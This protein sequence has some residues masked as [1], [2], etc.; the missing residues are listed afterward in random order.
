MDFPLEPV[1]DPQRCHEFLIGIFHPKGLKC[2]NHHGLDQAYVHKKD[3][4]PILD[5]RCKTCGR[6]FNVF[7]NTVL[8]GTKHNA[9][10]IVQL[11][12]GIAQGTPTARLAREMGVDRKW[13]LV[14]RHQ[15]QAL[16]AQNRDGSA[17]TDPVVETDELY[18]NA[19]EKRG[20]ARESRRS[21]QTPGQQTT[22]PRHVGN[23]PPAGVGDRGA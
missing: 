9:T 13:L 1:L 8:Q 14:R 2:P 17:L 11:L 18:Q 12:R 16:A 22:R 15:L 7:T 23:R 10:A 4:W 5:Y 6:C 21:T 19:G 3:R 20:K